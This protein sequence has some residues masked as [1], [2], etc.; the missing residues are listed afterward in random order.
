MAQ[1]NLGRVAYVNKGTYGENVTYTKYDVVLYNNGSYV[2]WNNADSSGNLPT[3]TTYWRVMLDP[4]A[5][6]A[7]VSNAGAATTAANN[8][9]SAANTAADAATSAASAANTAAAAATSAAANTVNNV[10]INGT[11]ITKDANQ[12]VDIPLA[13]ITADGAMSKEDKAA[14][15]AVANLITINDWDDIATAVRAGAGKRYFPAGT[16]LSVDITGG[17]SYVFDVAHNGMV[18]DPTSGN[19]KPGMYLLL[20]SAI[21]SRQF[22]AVEA[23]YYVDAAVHS[24]GLAAGTYHFTIPDYDTTYGGNKTYQFTLTNAVPAGGQIVFNWG[25]NQQ[26]TAGN[27]KT[28]SSATSATAIETATLSEGTGGT[29]LGTADGNSTN[30]NHIQRARYGSNNYSESAIRQW[31]NSSAAADAWWTPSNIFDRPVSYTNVAGF[32]NGLDSKFLSAVGLTDI[33]CKTNNTFELPGWTKNTAYNVRDKFFLASRNELGFGT[34]NVAEGAV[35]ELFN[36]ATD[37]DRIKYDISATTTARLWWM[38]SPLPGHAS[39]V[40]LVYSD[41]SLGNYYAYTGF[42]AVPACIIC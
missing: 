19:Q 15:E 5:M 17:G 31:I 38:R 6:N 35:W 2:Y 27:I 26:V 13:S 14:L 24:S 3:D 8:A 22:D 42:A 33:P 7:A 28:Y 34:E 4:S 21:N 30:M 29:N 23:L 32:L 41:G 12:V 39:I 16:Q 36:G 25:Y 1:L 20:H 9:A 18:I 37:S 10:K 40:R 11:T